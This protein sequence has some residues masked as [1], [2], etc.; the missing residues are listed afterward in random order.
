V[1]VAGEQHS[2][3]PYAPRLALRAPATLAQLNREGTLI[4]ADIHVAAVLARL[5][6][7]QDERVQRCAAL[8]VAAARRGHAYVELDNGDAALLAAAGGL[9]A[10]DEQQAAP[11]R[12]AGRRLY[13]DRYWRQERRLAAALRARNRMRADV[14]ELPALGQRLAA[15]FPGPAGDEQRAAAAVALLRGL[16]VIAGGPGTGKTTTVARI[17]GLLRELAATRGQAEPLIA[18]CAPTARA[19]ARL[20]QAVGGGLDAS[21][22]HRLLGVSTGERLRNDRQDRLPHD[23][24]IVEECSLVPLWLMVRLVEAVRD[25]A[26]L[27]LVG[28]PDQLAGIQGG[29]LLAEIVGPAANGPRR[30]AGMCAALERVL[31]AGCGAVAAS[32]DGRQPALGDA[33]ALLRHSHRGLAPIQHLAEAIRRGDGDQAVA[34]LRDQRHAQALR[35]VRDPVADPGVLQTHALDGYLP[36]LTTARAGDATAALA[37]LARF[38]LLCV[39]RHGPHGALSWAARIERWLRAELPEPEAGSPRY[40]GMA[41][42][43]TRNAP[44]LGLHSGDS[45]VVVRSADGTLQAVFDAGARQIAIAPSR[46]AD[47]EP[48]FA[49]TVHGSQGSEFDTTAVL[50]P[51]A[52]SPLLCRELLYTAVTRAQRRLVLAGGEAALR[53]ALARPA[54]RASTLRELLWEP[55]PG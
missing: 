46:L 9:V 37:A 8:A 33:I 51:E 12:L 4:A 3:D 19:A 30:S 54:G 14:G 27:I 7:V 16:S 17:V 53:K 31:G 1:S 35:W 29:A 52:E 28:D 48:L 42:A 38:R 24:V 22:M 39:H 40:P 10:T 25:D 15:A 21:T 55:M 34:L 2:H 36:M 43:M 44:E 41:L 45:G 47:V 49:Q 13:L 23:V 6:G 18:L 20:R 32:A 11:L 5:A 26:R 50:L